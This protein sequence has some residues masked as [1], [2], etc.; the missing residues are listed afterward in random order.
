M[1]LNRWPPKRMGRERRSTEELQKSPARSE[2]G[3]GSEAV[4]VGPV[5]PARCRTFSTS[6]LTRVTPPFPDASPLFYQP[7][8]P[9]A[10]RRWLP[11]AVG[12]LQQ[13][14]LG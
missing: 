7:L 10:E 1:K 3:H 12:D 13:H 6:S 5:L 14:T 9:G 11:L 4:R 8:E 2:R